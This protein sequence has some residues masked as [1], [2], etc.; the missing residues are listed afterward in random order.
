M[1][2][3]FQ[4]F[5]CNGSHRARAKLSVPGVPS[6]LG[7]FRGGPECVAEIRLLILNSICRQSGFAITSHFT[8]S[9]AQVPPVSGKLKNMKEKKKK[10]KKRECFGE[11][12]SSTS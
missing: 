5:F 9:P 8:H 6:K 10:G 2:V 1:G 12:K 11:I 3:H 4:R 7:I